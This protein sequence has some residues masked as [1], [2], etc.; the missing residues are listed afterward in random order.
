LLPF[1]GVVV[2]SSSYRMPS[3]SSL[4]TG[5]PPPAYGTG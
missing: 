4:W 3:C 1:S 5:F 2:A